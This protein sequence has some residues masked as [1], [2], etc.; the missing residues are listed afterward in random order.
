MT[1]Q[2]S[3]K[4]VV[5]A[6]MEKTGESYTAARARLLAAELP[7]RAATQAKSARFDWSDDGSRLNVFFSAKGMPRASRRSS[8]SASPPLRTPS[9]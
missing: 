9:G 3:F 4:R 7:E 8:T 2:K 5:R 1:R 6:R